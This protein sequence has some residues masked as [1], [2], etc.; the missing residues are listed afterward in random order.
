MFSTG[1]HNEEP[2][3]KKDSHPDKSQEEMYKDIKEQLKCKS[4]EQQE[5]ASSMWH[6]FSHSQCVQDMSKLA[7]KDKKNLSGHARVGEGFTKWGE[8]KRQRNL[9]NC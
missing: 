1:L 6:S 5:I 9:K 7:N 3:T 4:R 8:E 2:D